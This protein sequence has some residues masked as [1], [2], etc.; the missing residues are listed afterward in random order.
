MNYRALNALIIFNKNAF[1]LIKKTLA[2]LYVAKI[3]NKF[4]I[5]ITF[6]KVRI[7][8]EYKRKITF[9]TR[10]NYINISLYFSSY[11]IFLLSFKYL[12]T[13]YFENI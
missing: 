5:I 4:N 12:L 9:L 8:K 1:L 7:R 3:Y 11:I 10:Y 2:K 6:N 13:K